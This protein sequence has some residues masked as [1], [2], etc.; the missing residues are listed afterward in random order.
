MFAVIFRATI[1]HFDDEYF[2]MAKQLRELAQEKYGCLEFISSSENDQELAISYWAT[3]EDI[4]AWK[5]DALHQ[6]AQEKGRTRWYSHY[7]VEIVEVLR[8]Y[9]STL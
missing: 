7:S 2:A 5:Q 1:K 3:Q 6:V 9:S 8:R 4:M